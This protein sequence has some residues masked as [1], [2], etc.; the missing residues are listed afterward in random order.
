MPGHRPSEHLFGIKSMM[1][2]Y[3]HLDIPLIIQTFDISK[4]F[5]SEVLKDALGALH[6][7]GVSGKLY[8]LWFEMNK[9]TE[10][11]VK[12]GAGMSETTT[13]GETVAQG[14]IGGALISSLNLD[15]ELN[16]FFSGSMN[17]AAYSDIR[18]QPLILQDDLCRMSSSP[19]SARA[20]IKR[21]ETIMKLKQLDLNVSKSSYIVC[22]N[23]TKAK[24][25]Q[26]ELMDNPLKYD[27]IE[28]KEKQSEKYLDD[29]I[30]GRG[31]SESIAATIEERHGRIF[32]SV[33]E[34]RTILE[35]YRSSQAGGIL[36]G[37]MLWEMAVIPSL[38]NNSDTWICLED[39]S[40][41]ILGNFKACH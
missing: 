2:L 8:R 19:D 3:Q 38:L 15:V 9:E 10:I 6:D 31:L 23:S 21:I 35:D 36:A 5:D 27:G 1:I 12:T 29:M 32:S 26:K 33:L 34:I 4:Y 18:L 41:K 11:K 37:L 25:I 7:A 24:D 28:F 14:S 16:H 39:D 22:Q 20:G 13:V 40:I 30:D 17:E